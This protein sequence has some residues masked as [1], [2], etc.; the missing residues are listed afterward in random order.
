MLGD[1]V[2][3]GR[4]KL[5]LAIL[6]VAAGILILG[7]ALAIAGATLGLAGFA[8]FLDGQARLVVQEGDISAAASTALLAAGIAFPSAFY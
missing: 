1:A 8:L 5:L 7:C 3:T 4:L 2:S 6:H